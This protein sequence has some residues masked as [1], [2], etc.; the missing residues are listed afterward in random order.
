MNYHEFKNYQYAT[1]DKLRTRSNKPIV[2]QCNAYLSYCQNTRQMSRCTLK[3]KVETYKFLIKETKCDDLRN[4]TNKTYD[5]FV[6]SESERGVS[7]RT[8]NSRTA[9]IIAMV[10]YY[11]E[12]GMNIPLRIPLIPKLKE[13]PPRRIS[14]TREQIE[15]VLSGCTSSLQWLLI[16]ILFDTGMRIAE[17]RNLTVEQIEGKKIRFIGK[18]KKD[19]VVYI[20]NETLLRLKQYTSERHIETGRIWL[21]EWG[22]PMCSGTLRRIM[23]NAFYACGYTDFYPH[24]LRHSFGTDIQRQGADLMVIKEMMGHSNVTTT[25]K[26]LHGLDNRLEEMFEKYRG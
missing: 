1:Y 16:K 4:F 26:Y 8:I 17:L 25:Q 13:L 5:K 14:Y 22:Y 18:G 9:H 11:R 23:Q 7:A 24:A 12:M 10:R 3:S 20:G 6:K 2:R 19:R 21:N 15:E